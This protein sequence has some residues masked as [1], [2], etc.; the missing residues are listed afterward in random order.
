MESDNVLHIVIAFFTTS[1]CK[2]SNE[3]SLTAL[4]LSDRLENIRAQ[5]S[6]YFFQQFGRTYRVKVQIVLKHIVNFN[7]IVH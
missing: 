3:S 1:Y 2:R 5:W 6:L 7:G 4:V